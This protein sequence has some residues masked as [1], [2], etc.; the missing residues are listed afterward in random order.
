MLNKEAKE[1]VYPVINYSGEKNIEFQK[2]L[3]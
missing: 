2:L 3:K 1:L